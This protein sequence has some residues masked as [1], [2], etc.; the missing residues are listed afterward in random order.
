MS[1]SENFHFLFDGNW[2]L[3]G[4]LCTKVIDLNIHI[5]AHRDV[6]VR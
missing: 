1:R 4:G 5:M 2:I 3:F 6:L